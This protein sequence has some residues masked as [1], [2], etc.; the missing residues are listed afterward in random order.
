MV[1]A[2]ESQSQLRSHQT[3]FQYARNKVDTISEILQEGY[4]RIVISL[5]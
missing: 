5:F 2:L 1:E 3:I 4:F